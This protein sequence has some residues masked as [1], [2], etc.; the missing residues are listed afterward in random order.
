[1]NLNYLQVLN[2]SLNTEITMIERDCIEYV[3][4]SVA[5]KFIHKYPHL[6]NN[7]KSGRSTNNWIDCVSLGNLIYP[8]DDLLKTARLLENIF[9][10]YHGENN[11][12]KCPG[13]H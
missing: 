6:G 4:G 1:M 9:N 12:N 10:N 13:T 5:R 8:S 2:N 11:L 3:T 7:D